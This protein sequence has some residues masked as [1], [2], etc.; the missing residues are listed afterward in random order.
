MKDTN[1]LVDYNCWSGTDY[2]NNTTQFSFLGTTGISSNE[3]SY[4]GENSLKVSTT[5]AS[6]AFD[7]QHRVVGLGGTVTISFAMYNP[8]IQVRAAIRTNTEALTSV[9][10]PASSE[11]KRVT[12]SANVVE[13]YDWVTLRC[14]LD[15]VGSCFIDDIT[16]NVS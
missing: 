9:S 14:F 7:I 16:F 3:W 15:Q 12:V 4:T 6:Q 11:V 13:S 8:E 2:T 5:Q 10:I 1:N